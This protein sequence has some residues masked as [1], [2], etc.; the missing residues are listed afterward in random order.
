MFC[1]NKN[2]T[3]LANGQSN[4]LVNFCE[5]TS[6]CTNAQL[7]NISE[8][9]TTSLT[10]FTPAIAAYLRSLPGYTATGDIFLSLSTNIL[11][12]LPG[13]G[14]SGSVTSILSGDGMNFSTITSTGTITL[15]TPSSITLSSTNSLTTTSHTH[16]LAPGGTTAQYISGAGTLITFPTLTS[17]TVTSIAT[18]APITGGTITSTGTIGITQSTTSTNGYL[19]STDWNTFNNKLSSANNGLISTSGVVQLG[20]TVAQAS[21]PATLLSNREIP[22]GAVFPGTAY[23]LSLIRDITPA[24]PLYPTARTTIAHNAVTIDA[25]DGGTFKINVQDSTNIYGDS[26]PSV[27]LYANNVLQTFSGLHWASIDKHYDIVDLRGSMTRAEI[28]ASGNGVAAFYTNGDVFIG[29][30]GTSKLTVGRITTAGTARLT[31]TTSTATVAPFRIENT[32][33]VIPTSP[34]NG[35]F[36]I[37]APTTPQHLFVRLDGVTYQLD[38]QTNPIPINSLLAATGTNDINNDDGQQV[39]RWNNL[40][41]GHGGLRLQTSGWAGNNPGGFTGGLLGLVSTSTA[42]TA[43]GISP[44]MS[45]AASAVNANASVTTVGLYT[46]ILSNGTTST[47]IGAYYDISAATNNYAIITAT[48]A[49][50][51]FNTTVP[52][53]GLFHL[54]IPTTTATTTAS[55]VYEAMNSLTSGTGHYIATNSITTGSALQLVST[56]T[57]GDGFSLLNINLSGVN[58]TASK[59]A[60]GGV[61]SITNS[62]TTSTNIGLSITTSGATNNYPLKLVDGLQGAGKVLTSDANGNASWAAVSGG[63]LTVGTT[64][65]ASGTGGRMVYETSGNK[66]GEISGATSDGTIV[67]LTSPILTTSATTGS[68]SFTFINTAATTVAEYGAATT[69]T[70]GGTPTTVLTANIFANATAT[71]TTK[72]I[73]LGTGGASGSTTAINIGS[74]TSGATNNLKFNITPASDAAY[75]LYYRGATGLLTRLANG[76]TG[77]FLGANTSA[78]PTWQTPSGG[79]WLVTGTTNLTGNVSVDGLLNSVSVEIFS[80]NSGILFGTTSL[81]QIGDIRD[82]A[83]SNKWTVDDAN[84]YLY[85]DNPTH[86]AMVGINTNIP[87]ANFEVW[88]GTSQGLKIDIVNRLYS[89]GDA[90]GD[91]N[92]TKIDINDDGIT[93][94][95]YQSTAGHNFN[96]GRVLITDLAGAGA[97]AA[98]GSGVLIPFVSDK[99]IKQNIRPIGYGLNTV[100]KLRPSSWDM[101]AGWENYGQGSRIGFI[102][103]DIEKVLPGSVFTIPSLGVKSYRENDLIP[104]LVKGMQEQQLQIEYLQKQ[105]DQL[106]RKH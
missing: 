26:F 100:M 49:K 3:R 45:V 81:S 106:K 70:L 24:T 17:G 87:T 40:G 88:K 41:V 105:I 95:A 83:N 23:T 47:N 58:G 15:G 34:N 18:T 66:F 9:K 69:F 7:Q 68:S 42:F 2:L 44:L 84:G 65:I 39:W 33:A 76:T 22:V 59:I 90:N 91:N 92:S 56:S 67:T 51:G 25:V 19:S 79:G 63:G 62:G 21:N 75:D 12:W 93:P 98:D 30:V 5:A 99:F 72:T 55:G 94:I 14:G 57:V 78:A 102:A 29:G 16:T 4:D 36:W 96:G 53:A 64:A 35:E 38:Q 85:A 43:S 60:N 8:S 89:F 61:I 11:K 104:V 82:H 32:G 73:N 48:P 52:T 71:A 27:T 28:Q 80:N 54:V 6:V 50:V 86:T 46:Q 13:G 37:T 1:I 20:Q 97:V 77:Q 103:Q 74:A 10:Y 101:K 31:T